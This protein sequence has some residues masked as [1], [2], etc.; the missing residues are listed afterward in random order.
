MIKDIQQLVASQQQS[1]P[2]NFAVSP[3]KTNNIRKVVK[4]F[5]CS[6]QRSAEK[7]QC[8]KCGLTT[9]KCDVCESE[10]ELES[11]ECPVYGL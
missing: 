5:N 7:F 10:K 2:G 11:R 9:I 3:S 6:S 8:Y 1:Q 4:C